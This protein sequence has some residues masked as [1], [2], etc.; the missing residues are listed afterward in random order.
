[1]KYLIVFVALFLTSCATESGCHMVIERDNGPEEFFVPSKYM[2]HNSCFKAVNSGSF[3]YTH[4]ISKR[5]W[6]TE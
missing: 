5:V 1:M 3:D 2:D 4:Y 6:W